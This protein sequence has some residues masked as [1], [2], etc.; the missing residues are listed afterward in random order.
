M[1]MAMILQEHLLYNIYMLRVMQECLIYALYK[2]R[3]VAESQGPCLLHLFI[4]FK[5]CRFT[6]LHFLRRGPRFIS[7]VCW[8][9]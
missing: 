5:E 1:Y 8:E 7:T 3:E 4:F 2:F 6:A 9:R